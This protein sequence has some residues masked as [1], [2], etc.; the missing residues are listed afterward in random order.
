MRCHLI[1]FIWICLSIRLTHGQGSG[2]ALHFDGHDDYMVGTN[3]P[4][5]NITGSITLEAWAKADKA[6][7]GVIAGKLCTNHNRSYDLL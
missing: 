6:H 7:Y 4:E 2:H 3:A 1:L 5:V